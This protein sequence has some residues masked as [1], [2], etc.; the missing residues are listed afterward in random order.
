[1]HL[2]HLHDLLLRKM[3]LYSR[4]QGDYELNQNDTLT[5]EV[6]YISKS[7]GKSFLHEIVM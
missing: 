5:T 3:D 7:N 2:R 1:V 6:F 4:K